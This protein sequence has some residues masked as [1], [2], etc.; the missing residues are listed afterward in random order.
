MELALSR[1]ARNDERPDRTG[2]SALAGLPSPDQDPVIEEDGVTVTQESRSVGDLM[3]SDPIV[4]SIDLPLSDA[5]ETMDFYRVSGLPVVDWDGTLVGVISRTDL[6]HA[7]TTEALWRAW[8]GLTVRH[9]MARPAITV[10]STTSIGEAAEL[11]ERMHIDRLVVTDDRETPIG[12]LS[13]T[14]LVRSMA[15]R[16]P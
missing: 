7:R 15:E 2:H 13:I 12:L 4:V 9:L 16:D 8:P 1:P 5:A 3:T 10:T 14:D 6:L 11:M